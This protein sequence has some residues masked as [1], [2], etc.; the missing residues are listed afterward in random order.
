MNKLVPVLF[1]IL[2]A[3]G[4][5]LW[6]LASGSLNE[7]IKNQIES[8]GH[9]ITEQTVTV[10]NVDIRLTEGAGTINGF[11]LSNPSNYTYKNLFSLNSITLDI[12]L[13]SLTEDPIVIDAIIIKNPQAFVELTKDGQS[14]IKDIINAIE[15]NTV[16]QATDTENKSEPNI[17]VSKLILASTNLTID[18]SKLGNKEHR[19]SLPDIELTNIGKTSG[20]PASEL[21]IEITKQILNSIW[22]EA[23]KTQKNE[24]KAKLKDK[25]LDKLDNFFKKN[26]S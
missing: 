15:K 20:L 8:V 10:A 9:N 16:K 5:A 12:N 1:I 13:K 2:L 14:N 6:F 23:K 26:L 11:N 22:K 18:L 7:L 21:G 25:A 17:R 19:L 3:C 24:L 4:T